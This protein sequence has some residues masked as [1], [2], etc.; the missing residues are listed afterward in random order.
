MNR[1]IPKFKSEAE[2]RKFWSS[3]DSVDY[4]D[5]RGGKRAILTD[6]RPSVRAI[7]IRLPQ[8]MIDELKLIANRR[9]VPYQSLLKIFLAERLQQERQ[10]HPALPT[11]SARHRSSLRG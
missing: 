10:S 11:T 3:H 7:S 9:D 1:K 4:I 2:E 6:L 8:A 5:W